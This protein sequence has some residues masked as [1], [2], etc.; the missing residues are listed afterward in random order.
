MYNIFFSLVSRTIYQ[1]TVLPTLLSLYY[2]YRIDQS[3]C[4]DMNRFDAVINFRLVLVSYE[5]SLGLL[6]TLST[7]QSCF[8]HCPLTSPASYLLFFPIGSCPAFCLLF[9]P[10]GPCPAFAVNFASIVSISTAVEP[11]QC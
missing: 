1:C 8:V 7:N 4:F 3:H 9:F 11:H 10:I 5:S 6:C 2:W